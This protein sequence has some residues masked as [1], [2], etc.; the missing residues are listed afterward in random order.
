MSA[1]EA[2]EQTGVDYVAAVLEMIRSIREEHAACTLSELARLLRQP[3]GTMHRQ[4]VRMREY[5]L[6]TWDDLPGS[7]HNTAKGG[8]VIG[9]V[10]AGKI[11]DMAYFAE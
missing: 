5:G 2:R 4:L 3:K 10:R 8:K 1:T 9:L 7:L 6:V 11:T